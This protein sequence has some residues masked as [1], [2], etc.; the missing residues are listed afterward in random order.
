MWFLCYK[1]TDILKIFPILKFEWVFK[2]CKLKTVDTWPPFT[3]E[4]RRCS[5]TVKVI[6]AHCGS[7]GNSNVTGNLG[8]IW[9]RPQHVWELW[10]CPFFYWSSQWIEDK[11][12]ANVNKTDLFITVFFLFFMDR[13]QLLVAQTH[14][15]CNQY[16]DTPDSISWHSRLLMWLYRI[17]TYFWFVYG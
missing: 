8:N 12:A 4:L 2:D 9:S 14:K 7:S 1:K 16:L 11:Q 10:W 13:I 15:H 17:C 5:M 3:L 6:T